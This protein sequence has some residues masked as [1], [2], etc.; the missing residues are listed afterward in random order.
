MDLVKALLDGGADANK[1]GYCDSSALHTAALFGHDHVSK[2]YFNTVL[3][4]DFSPIFKALYF[5]QIQMFYWST[6]TNYS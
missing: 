5:F 6:C 3:S 4:L 2:I 1:V